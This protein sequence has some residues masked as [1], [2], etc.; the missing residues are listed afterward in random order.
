VN[1]RSFFHGFTFYIQWY[2]APVLIVAPGF[3]KVKNATVSFRSADAG[4]PAQGGRV[5]S[6]VRTSDDIAGPEREGA[7]PVSSRSG[8]A[9]INFL[10]WNVYP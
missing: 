4:R 10:R 6:A 2:E 1:Q 3:F 9:V 8:E 7:T 5:A